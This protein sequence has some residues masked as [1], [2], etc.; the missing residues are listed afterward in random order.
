MIEE[1]STILQKLKA[2]EE[3]KVPV[4][5]K[6]GMGTQLWRWGTHNI[7]GKSESHG[8]V[9]EK[10]AKQ[11]REDEILTLVTKKFKAFAESNPDDVKKF[12][13]VKPKKQKDIEE[14][15]KNLEE[16]EKT[17]NLDK[18]KHYYSIEYSKVKFLGKFENYEEKTEM[19]F[20]DRHG[21]YGS[22]RSVY[23]LTFENGE[24]KISDLSVSK[25]L[26]TELNYKAPVM[27]S[28]PPELELPD[29]EGGRK[30]KTHRNKKKVGRKSTQRKRKSTSRRSKK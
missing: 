4:S 13:L 29:K 9:Q 30:R 26:P 17:L 23:V 20:P 7:R 22:P 11:H 5:E 10:Y 2:R 1:E 19:F 8:E 21:E 18:E 14:F 3:K 12:Q 28:V 24:I 16:F 27:Y 25:G 6:K 15:E